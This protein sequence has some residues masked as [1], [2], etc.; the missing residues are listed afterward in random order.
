MSTFYY[1]VIFSLIGGVVSLIG[2]ILLLS[3]QRSAQALA[4]YATPFA[5]GALLAAVFFD[6]LKE[7]IENGKL[8]TALLATLGGIVIFFLAEGVFRWFH[9]H[10]QEEPVDP[11]VIDPAERRSTSASLIV[12]GDTLHNAL[13]GV[14]I[15]ASFL[16][17][18]PTGIATTIAVAAH[19]IP[20]EIGD[21]GLLL[22][23][24]YSRKKVL[25]VNLMSAMATVAVATT[26]YTLGIDHQLPMDL[27]LGL[28][29]GFLL[30]IAASDII[31]TIHQ[32]KTVKQFNIQAVLFLLGIAVV[33]FT[34]IAGHA[35]LDENFVH[36]ES[37]DGDT[38]LQE[39]SS[40]PTQQ[41]DSSSQTQTDQSTNQQP[42]STTDQNGNASSPVDTGAT[43]PAN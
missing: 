2:G 3:S 10:H 40:Q 14:A 18:I 38:H 5:G 21:F 29:A 37:D 6:L 42:S 31:P 25:T 12:V 8:E 32:S 28:S 34:T 16:I 9:H 23:K 11:S 35:V 19:E 7:A 20:Q 41:Q 13:D 43:E 1:V 26:V 30:Y 39:D 36:V 4:K 17:S 22:A 15:A 24:G 27:L 33:G